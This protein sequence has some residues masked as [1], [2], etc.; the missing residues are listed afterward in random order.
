MTSFL[1][2]YIFFQGLPKIICAW[3]ESGMISSGGMMGCKECTLPGG[4]L[5]PL[6]AN[7]PLDE[8]EQRGKDD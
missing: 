8:F 5:S 6:L 7:I 3:L 4:P 1:K 2:I